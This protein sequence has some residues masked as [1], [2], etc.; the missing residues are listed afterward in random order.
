MAD[1]RR[2]RGDEHAGWGPDGSEQDGLA[3]RYDELIAAAEGDGPL[4]AFWSAG[5]LMFREDAR[6]PTTGWP[7]TRPDRRR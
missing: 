2:E 1:R 4:R 3:R 6:G 7:T 5:K